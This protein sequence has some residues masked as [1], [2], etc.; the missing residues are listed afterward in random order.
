LIPWEDYKEFI[1]PGLMVLAGTGLLFGYLLGRIGSRRLQAEVVRAR[2]SVVE[3]DVRVKQSQAAHSKSIAGEKALQTFVGRLSEGVQNL[4]KARL[5]EDGV[6]RLIISLT[7][8]IFE[9]DQILLYRTV[10]TVDADSRGLTPGGVH[11]ALKDQDGL[12]QTPPE[13]ESIAFGDG[14]IGWVASHQVEM[15]SQDWHDPIRTEGASP[16]DNHP[17]IHGD[18]ICPMLRFRGNKSVTTGVLSVGRPKPVGDS[19][20]IKLM[21][22]T[23]THLGAIAYSHVFSLAEMESKANY[24]GLTGLMVKRH[25]REELSKQIIEKERVVGSLGVYIFDIDYFKNYNDTNGHPEGDELL[26]ELAFV[27][28]SNLRPSDLACRYGGEEFVIAMPG[29][30]ADTTFRAA[31]RIRVAIERHSNFRHGDKQPGGRLTISGGVTA[32]PQDGMSGDELIRHADEAL[33]QAKNSGRNMTCRYQG[34][35]FGGETADHIIDEFG[36]P[37]PPASAEGLWPESEKS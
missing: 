26:R 3:A 9:P 16:G 24:D 7:N 5:D 32:Y 31:E 34:I 22:Q 20:E 33:Y 14:K 25:F 8:A 15:T 23:I 18:L 11:L 28:K 10:K 37:F 19:R 30:D 35:Q 6:A 2:N 13:I 27:I 4:N 29:A 36:Q 1:L 21:L 17:S 12:R